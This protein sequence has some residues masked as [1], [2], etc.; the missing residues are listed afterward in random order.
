M[1][2]RLRGSSRQA[3]QRGLPAGHGAGSG[4]RAPEGQ[5]AGHGAQQVPVAGTLLPVLL[6]VYPCGDVRLSSCVTL[7]VPVMCS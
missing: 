7:S 2:G 3:G 5:A 4:S 1:A 6:A